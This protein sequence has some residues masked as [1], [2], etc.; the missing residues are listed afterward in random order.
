M[1]MYINI[2]TTVENNVVEKIT[3]RVS[4]YEKAWETYQQ[5]EDTLFGLAEIELID[6]ENAEIIASTFDND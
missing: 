5:L 1:T 6:G 3:L 4:G 2:L